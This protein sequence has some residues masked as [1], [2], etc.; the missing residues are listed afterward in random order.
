VRKV[1]K[2]SS[3]KRAINRMPTNIR[4]LLVKNGLL[5]LYKARPAYQQNDYLSWISQAKLDATKEKR[6]KQML[7]ELRLGNVYMNMRWPGSK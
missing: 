2:K 6:T 4:R 3:L 5:G 7:T 1:A